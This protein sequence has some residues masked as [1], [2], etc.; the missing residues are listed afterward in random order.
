[1]NGSFVAKS[2]INAVMLINPKGSGKTGPIT[3]Q[4]ESS[5]STRPQDMHMCST[6]ESKPQHRDGS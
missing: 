6:S 1:M 3:E 2:G 4:E 5:I